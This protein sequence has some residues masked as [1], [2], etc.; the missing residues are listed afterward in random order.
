MAEELNRK[1]KGP[2]RIMVWTLGVLIPFII[3]AAIGLQVA[4]A[5]NGPAVLSA[6]DRISGGTGEAELKAKI[7]TG[8]HPDQKLFVWGPQEQKAKTLLRPVLLFVHGG[9]WNS[10]D[11]E[12]YSFVARSFVEQGFV[13]VLSGYRLGEA[14][15]YPGMIED[16]ARAFAWAHEE[17]TQYGGDPDHIVIAGHSAGAYNMMMVALE[18]KWLGAHSLQP[19]DIAGVVGLSGPYDFLPLDS[20]ST[21]ASFGHAKDLDATQPINHVSEAAPPMLLIHGETDTTVGVFHSRN[22]AELLIDQGRD[23]TLALYPEMD[24][25]DP[26]V[27]IAA[28]WRSRRDIVPKI[29][30]FVRQRASPE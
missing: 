26:L 16:T 1:T 25:A 30:A 14:G 21:I 18:K 19:K 10:G 24:H 6:V 3:V 13:V 20:D 9:S 17:I 8:D 11:P 5:R 28:P 29:A 2:F 22:L 15:K 27:S 23:P 7:A 4:I 12:D